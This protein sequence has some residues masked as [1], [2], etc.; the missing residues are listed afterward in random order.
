MAILAKIEEEGWR[1][2][3]DIGKP[4]CSML[5][6][7]RGESVHFHSFACNMHKLT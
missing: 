7:K 2:I 4:F 1:E 3:H 5:P 6:K